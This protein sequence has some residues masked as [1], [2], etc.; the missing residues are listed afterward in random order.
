MQI[1]TCCA[2]YSLGDRRR[3]HVWYVYLFP[4]EQMPLTAISMFITPLVIARKD[5]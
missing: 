3:R 5:C 4:P 1:C 2:W